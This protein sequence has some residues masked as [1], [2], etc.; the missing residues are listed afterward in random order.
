MHSKQK[1]LGV[2]ATYEPP[3]SA[4]IPVK[5]YQRQRHSSKPNIPP[6]R[7]PAS[8]GAQFR[9]F[10]LS[11]GPNRFLLDAQNGPRS[12][13]GSLAI[14]AVGLVRTTREDS[15]LPTRHRSDRYHLTQNYPRGLAASHQTSFRSVPPDPELP[16]RTRCFPPGTVPIGTTWPRNTREY[17]LLPTKHRSDRY[18]LTQKYP[19]VLAATP[20]APFRSVPP[21]PEIP[22]SPR[23][24]PPDTVP[25]GT[26]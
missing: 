18:H 19:R 4:Q 6:A 1:S 2:D 9:A 7:L 20:Q 22:A 13:R 26:T 10:A 8:H 5:R 23:C 12:M 16:A 21:D 25:I 11:R 3:P 24:Y 17:S 15:L 14:L